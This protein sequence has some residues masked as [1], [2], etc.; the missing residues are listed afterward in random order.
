MAQSTFIRMH[1]IKKNQHIRR[2]RLMAHLF[3][4]DKI[5]YLLYCSAGRP[6]MVSPWQS[7]DQQ[8]VDPLD[9]E[10]RVRR[11]S[12]KRTVKCVFMEKYCAVLGRRVQKYNIKCVAMSCHGSAQPYLLHTELI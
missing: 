4:I 5:V 6:C 12:A 11:C 9:R 3:L 8:S 1:F 10:G 2:Q 7:C